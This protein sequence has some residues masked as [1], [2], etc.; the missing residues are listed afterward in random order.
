MKKESGFSVATL[1]A[2]LGATSLHRLLLLLAAACLLMACG[3]TGAVQTKVAKDEL[4]TS[5]PTEAAPD[6]PVA[7]VQFP[8]QLVGLWIGSQYSCPTS[9]EGFD[10]EDIM[11]ISPDELVGYEEVYKPTKVTLISQAPMTWK[12]ETL[13]DV[14]PSGI[15]AE[16]G[17]ITFSLGD[18]ILTTDHK[19]QKVHFK[20]CR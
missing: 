11:E 14:G 20:K 12:I 16:S 19:P 15:F 9:D 5:A 4:T 6:F 13:I 8:Q 3:A 18:G 17:P 1:P 2:L 7:K 10:G